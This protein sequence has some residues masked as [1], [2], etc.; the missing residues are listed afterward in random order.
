MA[1]I[2][3]YETYKYYMVMEVSDNPSDGLTDWMI[4][5]F[6]DLKTAKAFADEFIPKTDINRIE[7]WGTDQDP[8]DFTSCE[9]VYVRDV[10]TGSTI[11][12]DEIGDEKAER[13]KNLAYRL[14]DE[15]GDTPQ[16][17]AAQLVTLDGCHEII[18][19]LLET[20]D[21]ILE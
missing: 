11:C 9:A 4:A 12:F 5:C 20:I 17:I 1:N 14:S 16:Q 3:T 2:R 21:S 8:Q 7:I 19:Y 10:A 13:I 15:E 6:S 18:E